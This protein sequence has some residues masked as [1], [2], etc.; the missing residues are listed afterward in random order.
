LDAASRFVVSVAA[1]SPNVSLWPGWRPFWSPTSESLFSLYLCLLGDLK[2]IVDFD[3]EIAHRALEFRVA[4]EEL[5]YSQRAGSAFSDTRIS[6]LDCCTFLCGRSR[7]DAKTPT[8]PFPPFKARVA[9]E[10]S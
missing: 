3:A 6:G 8:K 7:S 1:A 4:E 2:G 5:Y 9:L 10:A